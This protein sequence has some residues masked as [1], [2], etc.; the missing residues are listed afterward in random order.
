MVLPFFLFTE[1]S[2]LLIMMSV[3]DPSKVLFSIKYFVIDFPPSITN[4]PKSF[5]SSLVSY[6][7]LIPVTSISYLPSTVELDKWSIVNQSIFSPPL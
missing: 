4:N 7:K 6:L 3:C 5:V 1:S 2:V